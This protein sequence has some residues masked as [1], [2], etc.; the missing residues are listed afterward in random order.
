MKKMSGWG[1]ELGRFL[2][3]IGIA[4]LGV[5]CSKS[6]VYSD[7][8]ELLPS[9]CREWNPDFDYNGRRCAF[10]LYGVNRKPVRGCNPYRNHP[11]YCS[12]MTP[13][14]LSYSRFLTSHQQLDALT[15]ISDQHFS[16]EQA[17]L[18]VN[19]GFLANGR[20]IIPTSYN[21]LS[22]R[23]PSRCTNFGTDAMA[24]MLEWLGHEVGRTYRGKRF[25]GVKIV[26][27]DVAAPRGGCLWGHNQRVAHRSHKNGQ[28]ADIGY[29][30]VRPGQ[31]SPVEFHQ[32]FEAKSNYWFLKKVFKNPYACVKFVFLDRRNI[33]KLAK[34]GRNDPD[35]AVMKH[36]IQH[37]NGHH[38]H[39]HIRIGNA[40]GSPGCSPALL[41]VAA[42]KV[43]GHLRAGASE[44]SELD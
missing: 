29:L 23:F 31:S 33:Q 4:I 39:F 17:Y 22:L 19:D 14:E 32:V 25:S 11:S 10:N 35:W 20:R 12:E 15:L 27:G 18:T 9:F 37:A 40:P 24:G 30:T 6:N 1:L 16:Q 41:H 38:N 44:V 7:R 8:G 13:G 2:A 3:V 28:D 43:K 5:G 21:H 42:L 34:V 26:V 36:F